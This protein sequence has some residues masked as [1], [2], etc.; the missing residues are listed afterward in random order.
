LTQDTVERHWNWAISG[1]SARA[2][3]TPS[4][5]STLTPLSAGISVVVVVPPWVLVA[6]FHSVDRPR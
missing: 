3:R 1:V 6:G 5:A 4:S 2:S